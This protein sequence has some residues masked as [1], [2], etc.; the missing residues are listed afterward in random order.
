MVNGITYY[1]LQSEY[2]GDTTKDCGLNGSEIDMNFHVL[3]GRDIE[4]VYVEDGA[5]NIRL[6][7]G[8]ILSTGS[9]DEGLAKDLKFSFDSENGVLTIENN[10]KVQKIEGF[11]T[12]YSHDATATDSTLRGNG[13][14]SR[15]LTVAPNYRTGEYRPV[16]RIIDETKGERLPNRSDVVP[17]D[18]FLVETEVSQNGFLYTYEGVKRIAC[19]LQSAHSEWRI[20]TKEDWDAMLNAIESNEGDRDHDSAS[21]AK[22]LGRMAGEMLKSTHMWKPTH[23]CVGD[24]V[25][26]IDYSDNAGEDAVCT[27]GKETMCSPVYCGEYGTFRHKPMPPHHSPYPHHG[28]HPHPGPHP[29]PGPHPCPPYAPGAGGLDKYGFNILPVGYADD[30]GLFGYWKERACYWT[31]TNTRGGASAFVKRFEFDHANVFQDMISGRNM[32][33]LRL[34]KDYNGENF[35]E[36]DSILGN[37]CETVLM[38]STK[39]GHAIWTKANVAF[40][41]KAYKPVMPNNGHGVMKVRKFFIYEWDGRKWLVNE[42]KEGE[43]VSVL[44][45]PNKHYCSPYK[46]IRGELKD[47][48][49]RM[50]EDVFNNVIPRIEHVDHE[51]H[52]EIHRAIEAENALNEKIEATNGKFDAEVTRIDSEISA[53]KDDLNDAKDH[54]DRVE[55][56]LNEFK[57]ET[58]ASIVSIKER[59]VAIEE[60]EASDVAALNT[61]VDELTARH[62]SEVAELKAKDEELDGKI[63]AAVAGAAEALA[64]EK[65]EREA[66]DAAEQEAREQADAQERSE[67]EAADEAEKT[68]REEKDAEHDAKDAEIEGKLPVQEGPEFDPDEGVLTIKSAA[69]T[70]DITV[71]F[72]FNFGDI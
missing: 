30:G 55:S 26:A 12:T 18:R 5:V 21:C 1:R 42:L 64:Q 14:P 2:P 11:V 66:A 27:C 51:L 69:G 34:V 60:K 16:I 57:V 35:N 43:E 40:A 49:W 59:V 39:G 25:T 41:D 61:R 46:V 28:P 15:P 37:D 24:A 56:S 10:G 45:A 19:D 7:N 3:E 65:A 29:G 13:K 70:N 17:G 68:A 53:V 31:A 4:S 67:R 71:Q 8:E 32:V 33:S 63:D 22:Y 44:D 48:E 38:P 72:G 47:V 50:T 36:R 54:I 58:E 52:H 62:D 20:P 9:M 6:Y 23:E